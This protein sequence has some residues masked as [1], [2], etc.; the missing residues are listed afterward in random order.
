MADMSQRLAAL[1]RVTLLTLGALLLLAA[2]LVLWLRHEFARV[3]T[4]PVDSPDWQSVQVGALSTPG[5][6]RPCRDREPHKRALFGALH[7]HTAASYD[8]AAFGTTTT[9]EQAYR[10]A[11]G[12]PVALRLRGDPP[13]YTAPLLRI[14]RPLDFMA[15]TDHAE[16]LGEN[17]L[18]YTPDSSAHDT[19]VCRLY[20]GDITLPV[21]EDMQPIV[22]LAS[23]A[24]FGQDRSMRICG[25]DGRRCDEQAASAWA[26]NQRATEDQHD[27]SGDCRFTTFHAYEYSL[28][29]A[30]ANLHRNVI[31]ASA[32][33]PRLPAGAREAKSPEA[34]WQWLQSTCVSKH[35]SC[36]ALTIPHN[37][38]WS[39]GR[40]W[41]PY[42]NRP[43][44][45]EQRM[46]QAELRAR[47]EPLAEV[48]Q[49]KGDSEC[50]N[51][52]ASV[53]GAPDEF[54]DFE[55][56][57]PARETI[58]DCGESMGEGG[59]LLSGC[60]SR[61]S[62][63]RYA[64]AAGIGERERL[65]INPFEFGIVAASDSHNGAPAANSE[66]NY[67]GSHGTD[68]D[69]RRRL[70]GELQVPGGIA[71][72]SPVRYNPGGVAGVYAEE[73]SR[74]A[75][76]AA[77]RRREV[78]GT[79]GPRIAPRFFALPGGAEVNCT[80]PDLLA[81][82]Y[83]HGVP[84][85]STITASSLPAVTPAFLVTA[86]AD[87][88][89]D[90][91]PLQRIQIVKLWLDGDG[92]TH[93]AVYDVAGEPDND[94]AVDPHT[95]QAAGR[96]FRQLCATWRDPDFAPATSAVYYA[97]VLQ[98]PSCRWSRH[99]CLRLPVAERPASCTD[100]DLPWQI[101][102]R[103]WTSPIWYYGDG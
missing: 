78:F 85:G 38:N 74:S 99:D 50:R 36:D 96:G 21:G 6:E 17:R 93:Q 81:Q 43:L 72:G 37:S 76:F 56:L 49:T 33:V 35:E 11:R 32:A 28:A 23:L 27:Y 14:D 71:R 47:M 83:A 45:P 89:N 42:S 62:F 86:S 54:C 41:F 66:R 100:P 20:R 101:Q 25:D 82:A 10:F 2:A 92:T 29:E 65:G 63:L 94:A 44:E 57:R 24:I 55:K 98:N 91:V 40:M 73:N 12:E 15:V 4:A 26:E 95:C 8:A 58:E 84:M 88:A 61:Y 34:L 90:A 87:P 103:A 69:L 80:S 16:G 5:T 7:V 79:S 70:R 39:S 46:R 53:A 9:P 60:V 59:M 51:G 22:R 1:L 30:S 48:M 31:F 67:L 97:R 3:S 102:E 19:L 64:L 75:I 13:D 52:I 18:C 77:L 68:R